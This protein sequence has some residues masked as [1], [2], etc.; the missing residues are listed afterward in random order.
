MPI[1]RVSDVRYAS[2]RPS[3]LD[4]HPHGDRDT[5]AKPTRSLGLC[6]LPPLVT[7]TTMSGIFVYI[8]EL[9][10]IGKLGIVL[11]ESDRVG[12]ISTNRCCF[13]PVRDTQ[14]R[15]EMEA[16]SAYPLTINSLG[17]SATFRPASRHDGI[18][19]KSAHVSVCIASIAAEPVTDD[20]LPVI[21]SALRLSRVD[22]MAWRFGGGAK[23]VRLGIAIS[24]T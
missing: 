19:A 16:A 6:K 1:M 17:S 14:S 20:L 7:S 13:A 22:T 9:D 24:V 23:R 21:I 12:Q 4:R 18:D 2:L 11:D 8:K 15:D 10:T 3:D 5:K